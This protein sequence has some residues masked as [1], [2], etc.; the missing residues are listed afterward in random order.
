MANSSPTFFTNDAGSPG[1]AVDYVKD[2]FQDIS[3]PGSAN[4]GLTSSAST[5]PLG[6]LYADDESTKFQVKTLYIKDIVLVE[7]RALWVSNKPTYKI[8]WNES[9]PGVDGY[10]FGAFQLEAK[11]D[12]AIA[13]RVESIGD[14][15][16][17][18][19]VIRKVQWLVQSDSRAGATGQ[20]V[21]DGSSGS[22]IDYSSGQS[23]ADFR[24]N[25]FTRYA[26]ISHNTVLNSK[27]IH[28]YRL[29]AIQATTSHITGVVVYFE[30]TGA[31]IDQFFGTTY[32]NKNKSTTTTGSTLAISAFGASTGGRGVVYKTTSQSY[33]LSNLSA[34]TVI[35]AAQGNSGTNL[36]TVTTGTGASYPQGTGVV[37]PQGTSM[38]VG[39]VTNQSTDT[40]TLSPTLPFGIS[41]IIYRAWSSSATLSIGSSAYVKTKVIDFSQQLGVTTWSEYPITLENGKYVMWG[42]NMEAQTSLGGRREMNFLGASG[43]M[44]V[45]GYF[46]AA[47]IEFGST[48]GTLA[49]TLSV[50]GCPSWSTNEGFTGISKRTW[51]ANAGPGWNTL[52]FAPGASYLNVGIRSVTLYERARDPGV[53]FGALA[54][55]DTLQAH[56]E[57]SAINATLG[58]L[59]VYRRY[60]GDQL[61]LQGNWIRTESATAPG[62]VEYRGS[63][64]NCTW[65]TEW[66]GKNYAILGTPGTSGVLT[67]DAAS[68]GVTFGFPRSVASEGF[69][70]LSYAHQAGTCILQGF[71]FNRTYGEVQSLLN[72]APMAGMTAQVAPSKSTVSVYTTSGFGT[73]YTFCPVFTNIQEFSG[74]DMQYRS[75]ATEG[76]QVIIAKEGIYTG[77]FLCDGAININQQGAITLNAP[78]ADIVGGGVDLTNRRNKYLC[79]D[80]SDTPDAGKYAPLG[81][82]FTRRLYPGDV[83]RP[84]V[85]S[86]SSSQVQNWRFSVTRIV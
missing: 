49:A 76:A 37:V 14:G 74:T 4:T 57:R 59:G 61:F 70:T 36:V 8:I 71:E 82:Y 67:V 73:T 45:C 34:S 10:C 21:T 47:E 51:L 3:K 29:T 66:Y 48:Q 68:V 38:Y 16:G 77:E 60:F 63:T 13:L 33:A 54:Q 55:F 2:A 9:F 5:N 62:F 22:T 19:G 17:V 78:D 43:F 27:D 81:M 35:S 30:N 58:S 6:G 79:F 28:D 41:N 7:D 20:L 25:R 86:A 39:S 24:A 64:N 46:S 69:H 12:G 72:Y 52:V 50:N 40:L 56:T 1:G 11:K 80:S 85:S 31:N 18:T 84:Q 23:V 44:Q 42:S 53:T 83:L 65:K 26:P 15:M 32:V 75:S